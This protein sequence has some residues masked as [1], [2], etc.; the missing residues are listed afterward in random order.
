MGVVYE[1]TH[2]A[3]GKR[4]ALKLID[5]DNAQTLPDHLARF[6]RE[7]RAA[8]SVDTQHIVQVLD[9]G[10][11][12][13]GAPYIAMELLNG[14]DLGRTVQRL[15]PLPPAV[16]VRIA[17]QALM[18]LVKAH[19]AGVI[20]R[21][22][23]SANLFLAARD[24]DELLVKLLDFGVAKVLPNELSATQN[25]S[26]TRTGSML[27]SPLYMSPEQARGSKEVDA[28]TD[29]WSLG[30]VMY[31]AL[32]GEAPHRAI[33]TL[34]ELILA[35]CSHPVT[36]VQDVAPWVA[37]GIARVVHRALAIRPADRYATAKDMLE[38]VRALAAEGTRIR[39][40]ELASL[41]PSQ[42]SL[43]APRYVISAPGTPLSESGA[44]ALSLALDATVSDTLEAASAAR[45]APVRRKSRAPVF[46]GLALAGAAMALGGMAMRHYGPP[47]PPPVASVATPTPTNPVSAT[48]PMPSA[49]VAAKTVRLRVGPAAAK[50]EV[51]GVEQ[52]PSD[53]GVSI[54]GTLGSLHTVRV[55]N[56]SREAR[57]SVAI[58]ESGPMPDSLVLEDP[59]KGGPRSRVAPRQPAPHGTATEPSASPTAPPHPA[60]SADPNGGLRMDTEFR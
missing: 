38:A 37:P 27:G 31:E 18:G 42:R 25:T 15:G 10:S 36:P 22:I 43:V 2:A 14:E 1:A 41:P 54:V 26:I 24:D 12:E 13:S 11:D 46:V 3:T 32:T 30:V 51:D 5:A 52:A 57:A 45:S 44:K 9:A 55:W 21:D 50:V 33:E 16:V 60:A 58:T 35:I 28:R 49:T 7:A 53:D 59:L 48:A 4:V 29:L 8:G 47:R 6:E 39:A 40:T 20:H 34:G 17:A 19:E 56:G 23:K